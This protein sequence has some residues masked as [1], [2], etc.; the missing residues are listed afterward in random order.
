MSNKEINSFFNSLGSKL[1]NRVYTPKSIDSVKDFPLP[2]G[3]C[4]YIL[5]FKRN[6]LVFQKGVK[7]MLGYS[8]SEFD[9]KKVIDIIHPDDTDMLNRLIRATLTF[10]TE[11]NVSKDVAFFLTYRIKKKNGDYIKVLRQSNI[12]DH[13]NTGKIISN[14]SVL[15]DVSF[16]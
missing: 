10:A 4:F 12:F 5:D 14:I 8:E 3:Q 2:I 16:L 7:E 11:N 9:V 15:S 6:K 13:D 1:K